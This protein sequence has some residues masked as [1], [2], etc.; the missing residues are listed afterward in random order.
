MSDWAA[1]NHF[2]DHLGDPDVSMSFE[3]WFKE[4]WEQHSRKCYSAA[5]HKYAFACAVSE[6]KT[7][8]SLRN[9]L[10]NNAEELGIEPNGFIEY[11]WD[12]AVEKTNL[13]DDE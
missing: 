13:S 10:R 8:D 6:A 12:R 4:S 7:L 2:L 5:A 3:N 9:L 11:I 1:V